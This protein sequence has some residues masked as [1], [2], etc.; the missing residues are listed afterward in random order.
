VDSDDSLAAWLLP[1]DGAP[2][3]AGLGPRSGPGP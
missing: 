2:T 3:G 1:A